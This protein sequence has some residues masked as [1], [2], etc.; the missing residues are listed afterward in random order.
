[1]KETQRVELHLHTKLSDD[2]SVIEPNEALQ[3][4]V[5]QSH[6]AVA[7][8]NLNNVQDFPAILEAHKKCVD[9]EI[10]VIYGAEVRY[11]SEDRKSQYGMTMLVKNQ[12]GIKELYKI[13]S[14][15]KNDSGSDLASLDVVKQNR[16]NL[17]IGSCGNA[18]E[19]YESVA[20]GADSGKV[21][22]FYDYLEIYPTEDDKERAIYKKIYELGD[23]HG[24]PVAATGNCHFLRKEDELYRRVVRVVKGHKDDNRNLYF[25]STEEMLAEFSYLGE[26]AAHKS[27]ITNPNQIA[28][29]ISQATPVR[30]EFYPLMIPNA[31]EKVQELAYARARDIYGDCISLKVSERLE[32]ELDYIRRHRFASY[33]WIAYRMVSHMNELGYYVGSRGSVGSVLTAFLLGIT[34]TNPLPA[35]YYCPQCH[36]IDF[37][38]SELDGFDLPD[39]VCPVCGCQLRSDGHNIPFETFMGFDG[40]KLPD[41]DLN[42]PGSMIY[43]EFSF[44]QEL[45]G[46]D[47]VVYAGTMSTLNEKLAHGY[48]SAYETETTDCFTEE[49]RINICEKICGIKRSDGIH[50]GKIVL[51]PRGMEFEDITPLK[52]NK[53]PSPIKTATHFYYHS[54]YNTLG[55]MDV[56]GHTTP[57]MLKL[58]EDFTGVALESVVWNDS[59]VYTLF[60]H[61]DTSGI[62]EFDNDFMKNMLLKIMPES[63]YDLVQIWGI[64]HGTGIWNENGEKLIQ[65]GH[66]ISE[67]TAFRDDVFLQLMQHGL[68]KEYAKQIAECVRMGKLYYDSKL[69]LELIERMRNKNV[70]E[71]Y[72]Q[73]LRKIQYLYPKA[74]AVSYVMNSVRMAW[75]KVHYPTEFLAACKVIIPPEK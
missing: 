36:Y 21:A 16:E 60:K 33:Y 1:M 55:E 38:V 70:P 73:Y 4:A 13:I 3:Y 35:H 44:I 14:S 24:I 19:L 7:F 58:V 52:E 40:S 12:A 15:I 72:I 11:M 46:E 20:N 42:F 74:H 59:D 54:L 6:K 39:Q 50:P 56:L 26:D 31:Y 68:E 41:I 34:D 71:W 51:L 61:A 2:I 43:N 18:G 62:P 23:K 49:Q 45:F 5:L 8:T 17:L 64:L 63:F 29:L 66:T 25:H 48:I 30:E 28:D 9:S 75:Y 69:S 27:V 57:D 22:A 53:S 10:K 67:L 47:K 32:I 65:D 37:E